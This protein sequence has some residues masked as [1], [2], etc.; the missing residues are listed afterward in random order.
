M[1]L[2][3]VPVGFLTIFFYAIILV[4]SSALFGLFA[5]WIMSLPKRERRINDEK[6]MKEYRRNYGLALNDALWARMLRKI[7]LSLI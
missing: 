1:Q 2:P 4:G 5:V 6:K 3:E 7:L